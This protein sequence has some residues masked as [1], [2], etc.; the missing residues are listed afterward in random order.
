MIEWRLEIVVGDMEII[1]PSGPS[2]L[3]VKFVW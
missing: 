3:N 2:A 1:Q